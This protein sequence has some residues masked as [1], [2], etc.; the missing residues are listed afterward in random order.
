[1]WSRHRGAGW[2]PSWCSRMRLGWGSRIRPRSTMP[3]GWSWWSG[4]WSSMRTTPTSWRARRRRH[5]ATGPWPPRWRRPPR[6]RRPTRARR[7][8]TFRGRSVLP[9]HPSAVPRRSAPGHPCLL[10]SSVSARACHETWRP[11]RGALPRE[12][13]HHQQHEVDAP[14]HRVDPFEE[15]ADGRVHDP[16]RADGEGADEAAEEFR[17]LRVPA[18]RTTGRRRRPRSLWRSTAAIRT[19]SARCRRATALPRSH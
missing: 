15:L 17:P 5:E 11:G 18:R 12:A 1:M 16:D 10:R 2:Q 4:G 19:T 8:G 3:A 9:G 14:H 13:D 6:R 7:A